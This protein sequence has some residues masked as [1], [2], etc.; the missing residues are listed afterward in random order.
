MSRRRRNAR[1]P[2]RRFAHRFA[3]LAF[4]LPMWIALILTGGEWCLMPGAHAVLPALSATALPAGTVATAVGVHGAQSRREAAAPEAAEHQAA[5]H[6]AAGHGGDAFVEPVSVG[7]HDGAGAGAA[8]GAA[9]HARADVDVA[10][11][12]SQGSSHHGLDDGACGPRVVC[13]VAVA[14]EVR[15]LLDRATTPVVRP[16][17]VGVDRPTSVTFA[18]E[19]PP[20]RA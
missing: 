15:V 5:A 16:V 20:P 3:T 19:I 13:S 4:S 7:A 17:I 8:A 9:T 10:P 11:S 2:A 1:R 14:P 12:S 6:Q 18:P